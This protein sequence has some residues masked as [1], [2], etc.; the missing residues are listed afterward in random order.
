MKFGKVENPDLVDF[1]FPADHPETKRVLNQYR[2]ESNF[3]VYVGCAKWN[4]NDLKGFYPKGVKDELTYYSRQFNAIEM[5]ATFYKMPDWKQVETWK[6]K[7]PDGFKFFPKVT[8]LI[9]HYRRLINV[10]EPIENFCDA[11]SNFEEKLGMA[12]MQL[13]ENFHPKDFDRLKGVLEKFPKAIP[14]AVEV[15]NEEWF[16]NQEIW[17]KYCTL[18]EEQGMANTIVDTAGRRDM[19]HMRPTGPAAFIRYVGANH[20]SDTKRLDDWIGRIK[21]W[22]EEGLQQLYFFVHQNVEV[23]SPLLAAYF[24]G[25]LNEELGLTLKIPGKENEALPP[26]TLFD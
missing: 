18:L 3:E 13:H 24:I 21:Q 15:R 25:R 19:L 16:S 14:L 4:R 8:D 11:V 7:T 5:N 12:F 17:E 22:K 6:N 20:P 26:L 2:K 10:Q 9:T 1:S 23:E